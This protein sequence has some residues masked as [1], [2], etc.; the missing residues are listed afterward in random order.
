[1]ILHSSIKK[2]IS[3]VR[4]SIKDDLEN[5][6]KLTEM[7]IGKLL[8]ISLGILYLVSCGSP[9]L[10]VEMKLLAVCNSSEQVGLSA[11]V[12]KERLLRAGWKGNSFDIS[13]MKDTITL[14]SFKILEKKERALLMDKGALKIFPI[15]YIDPFQ[16]ALNALSEDMDIDN[17]KVV[18][19]HRIISVPNENWQ[20]VQLKLESLDSVFKETNTFFLPGKG[21]IDDPEGRFTHIHFLR[22]NGIDLSGKI[23]DSK[24]TFNNSYGYPLIEINLNEKG[25]KMF[26]DITSEY[27]QKPLSMVIDNFVHSTPKVNEPIPGGQL[28]IT[29]GFS[30]D[31]A[32]EI[33]N[34]LQGGFLPCDIEIMTED[35]VE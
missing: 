10:P 1:M 29:G 13:H 28:Q 20:K 9:K 30:I 21:M 33:A 17:S 5:R 25:A 12:I 19:S 24:A 2:G 22:N 14:R 8:A 4:G 7:K 3:W 26:G 27:V 34:A 35:I 31:E 6:K 32:E 11:N 23:T 18:E 16:S 15:A